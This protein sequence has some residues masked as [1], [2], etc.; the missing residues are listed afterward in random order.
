MELKQMNPCLSQIGFNRTNIT[1]SRDKVNI[2]IETDWILFLS[3]N[4][5]SR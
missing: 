1:V 2:T 4:S 5:E 3:Y